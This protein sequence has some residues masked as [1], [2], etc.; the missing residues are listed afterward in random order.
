MAN[1]NFKSINSRFYFAKGGMLPE[2]RPA[3]PV[4]PRRRRRTRRPRQK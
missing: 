3:T 1:P 2:P 4:K